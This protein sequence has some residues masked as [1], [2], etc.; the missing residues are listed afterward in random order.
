MSSSSITHTLN[1]VSRTNE[2]F[3]YTYTDTSVVSELFSGLGVKDILSLDTHW[4]VKIILHLHLL[5][6][7]I[8]FEV[9]GYQSRNNQ[10]TI[11]Y[12]GVPRVDCRVPKDFCPY[13]TPERLMT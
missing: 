8:L 7:F 4:P 11:A 10:G 5:T 6:L 3:D 1:N 13:R 2:S 12:C 9:G